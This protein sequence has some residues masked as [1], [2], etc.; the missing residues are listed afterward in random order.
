MR[1]I[2]KITLFISLLYLLGLASSAGSAVWDLESDT[3]VA[4]DALNR[5]LLGNADYGAPK[6]NKT[7]GIFYFLWLEQNAPLLKDITKLKAANLANPDWGPRWSFHHW[8]ESELGYYSSDD[9]YVFRRHCQMLTDA[10]VDVLCFDVTNALTYTQ[11]YMKLCSA[12]RKIRNE[13]GKTPQICFVAYASTKET[14]QKLYDEFYSQNLYPELW[15][16]WLGKPLILSTPE[17]LGTTVQNFFTFRKT[18]AWNTGV[19]NWSFMQ[20][21]PQPVGYHT[22][23]STPE[24]VPVGI[25]EH[26]GSNIG[27]SC[28]AVNTPPGSSTWVPT[29]PPTDMY[30][31][32]ATMDQGLYFAQQWSRV[33]TGTGQVSPPFVFITGWNEWI[34]Q[35]AIEGQDGTLGNWAGHPLVAGDTW[36]V[37]A[38]SQEYSR[39]IEPMKGGHT[40]NY[41]YQMTDNIRRYKGARATR[42][43][44]L[45]KTI[46]VDGSFSDW[47]G[48][49]PEYRDHVGDTE[50]RNSVGYAHANTY[51]N[52][53]GRNDFVRMKVAR[54]ATYVYFYAETSEDITSYADPNWMLLYIDSDRNNATGWQ[55]YDYIVNLSMVSPIVTT[56]K[57]NV[58]GGWSWNTVGN[59][60]YRVAGNRIEMSIPRSL[61]GQTGTDVALDFH[62]ADNLQNPGDITDFFLNGD[63][64]PNRRFKYRFDG[65]AAGPPWEF[66][67]N[68]EGW[69]SGHSIISFVQA[70][71]SIQGSALGSDPYIN[72]PS[73]AGVNADSYRYVQISMKN[74]TATANTAEIRWKTLANATYAAS[75]GVTFPITCDNAYHTY[76]ISMS[77]NAEWKD[78][79]Y[80]LQLHPTGASSGTFYV[81]YIRVLPDTAGPTGSISIN[82]GATTAISS[83]VTLSLSA[84]DAGVGVSKMR[85]SNDGSTWTAWEDYAATRSW[86]LPI[87][88]SAKTV[89][90][91]YRDLEMNRSAT[92]SASI[93]LLGVPPVGS[94]SINSGATYTG[95]PAVTLTV[96]ATGPETVTDMRFMNSGSDWTA[97]E[98]H[99]ASKSWSLDTGDGPK[100]VYAQFRD[101]AGY[102]STA[103]SDDIALDMSGPTNRSITINS[104]ASATKSVDV[105]LSVSASDVGT[106]VLQ[107]RFR[108]SGESWPA[109][110]EPYTTSKSWSLIPGDGTKSVS[111]QFMDLA[112]NAA[113][114]TTSTVLDTVPP[115]GS[116]SI[117]SG[118]TYANSSDVTLALTGSDDRS[119][120]YQM[121]FAN[122]GGSWS[123]WQDF[124][125]SADWTLTAGDGARVVSAEFKDYAGNT[126]AATPASITI[127]TVRPSVPGT[128]ADIGAYTASNSVTFNWSGSSDADSGMDGYVCRVGST[129][130]GSD[131]FDGDTG[132]IATKTIPGSVGNRYYCSARARDK[133]GNLSDWS[134]SS[135]GIS[136]VA[137]PGI[138]IA[139]AKALADS[140]SVGLSS[141]TVTAIFGDRFYI[142]EW[143]RT[144]G[145]MVKPVF[146][147][148][149]G[150]VV[151]KLVD[152]GGPISVNSDSERW[153][154]A[155][156]FVR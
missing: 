109:T 23:P 37:D 18:W 129:P 4:T 126:V 55:G 123:G 94:V 147:M 138:D 65:T 80:A 83:T 16:H 82:S 56:V 35:R 156:V 124:S 64:A 68:A 116:I 40:D 74:S 52:N 53:T 99:G 141:K 135:D 32:C 19:D 12:F 114:T 25:A 15:Y 42:G 34:A 102:I 43:A 112:G 87:G 142:G 49:G 47:D 127:D 92:Y 95:I 85:L 148:P 136:I 72:G 89:Y 143:P 14:V 128:P 62:W 106:S 107:M 132:T 150:L 39:D 101:R 58:G 155:T 7:V 26:P 73:T 6:A 9:E 88:E 44:G 28:V 45:T 118:A 125:S 54:D 145:I 81:D 153:I 105:A 122:T 110:W 66:S 1:S 48:V 119:G 121:R 104:G 130:D 31:H 2:R 134:I 97:W 63:S 131:V 103:V 137:H 59:A 13:G 17:G 115:S 60:A 57:A 20:K 79:V 41:Y 146:G 139:A 46:A 96:S 75:R 133:A 84:T 78:W 70:S 113:T 86:N 8:G 51:V 69:S 117:N 76:T 22:S 149:M 108:N 100:T 29:E 90:V 154:D 61:I 140:E 33:G 91:Q 38:Y 98:V 30:G 77:G 3:W 5:S 50:H 21:Y 11:Q 71:G 93:Q 36:F 144:T 24:S 152:V 67:S 111:V 27:R 10:G 120:I 151:G